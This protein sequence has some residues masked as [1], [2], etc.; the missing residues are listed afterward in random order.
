MGEQKF[1]KVAAVQN[2]MEAEQII[3]LLKKQH[4]PAYYDGGF[5]DVYTG[6][7]PIAGEV[8]MVP[9]QNKKAAEEL[10]EEF[11]IIQCGGSDHHR[12]ASIFQRTVGWILLA[13]VL[14]AVILSFI[15]T[16]S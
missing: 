5:M 14:G 2:R 15:T 10:L 9:E 1:V 7:N 4:I 11:T 8:I 13:G 12:N 3:K 6:G 16:I